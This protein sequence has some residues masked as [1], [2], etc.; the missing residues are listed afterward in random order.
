MGRLARERR[1]RKVARTGRDRPATPP[2]RGSKLSSA[3]RVVVA[4]KVIDWLLEPEQPSVRFRTLSELLDRPASDSEVKETRRAIPTTGWVAEILARRDPA[5]WWVR[6]RSLYTPKY[7]STNWNMLALS[8][9][10]A[11]RAMPAVRAS[12]ELWMVR[13]PLKG[14]G[15]GG[16]S[17]GNGHHCYTGNMARALIRLGYGD[18][19]RV[20]KALDWL[21]RT[22]NPR[23]GWTCWAFG[24]GPSAGRTLDSWEGLSAFA[25]YPRSRWTPA[26]ATTV[27]RAA[28]YYLDHELHRQGARYPAWYRFHW[29]V[30][31]YYDVLVG[32]DI[33]TALGYG[34]DPRLGFALALL[35]KKRRPDGRWNLDANHPDLRGPAAEYYRKHPNQRP[36]PLVLER[37]GRASKMITLRALLVEKRVAG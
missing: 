28:E 36:T 12:A 19:P 37:P 9:L 16:F 27:G 23:G 35:R 30:H 33:L 21:V 2:R 24:D 14:G 3:S 18:D 17:T 32:L 15:V 20:L 26:M 4:A 34:N 22:A 8:E 5:G 29:P 6:E 25:E 31:Y 1:R 7:L 11:T 13:S 10:G